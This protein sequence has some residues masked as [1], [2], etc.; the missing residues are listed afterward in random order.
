MEQNSSVDGSMDF[1]PPKKRKPSQNKHRF[2]SLTIH[3]FLVAGV[4]FKG[5]RSSKIPKLPYPTP[6]E[7]PV[8]RGLAEHITGIPNLNL[9]GHLLNYTEHHLERMAFPDY[10][11]PTP[12]E[13]PLNQPFV[14]I[15]G[16]TPRIKHY[17]YRNEYRD[18][19]SKLEQ[20]SNQEDPI[21]NYP[22][23]LNHHPDPSISRCIHQKQSK[24]YTSPWLG[25]PHHACN[26]HRQPLFLEENAF[27][28]LS[29][30]PQKPGH[31]FLLH[32]NTRRTEEAAKITSLFRRTNQRD[33]DHSPYTPAGMELA[34]KLSYH[35]LPGT[36]PFCM[37][38][39]PYEEHIGE[40][41]RMVDGY[42]YQC[43]MSGK[44]SVEETPNEKL[45]ILYHTPILPT[46][47]F[48][49]EEH[50]A[51]QQQIDPEIMAV[52]DGLDIANN[53]QTFPQAP[54]RPTDE[55]I[56]QE[57]TNC[58]PNH[59]QNNRKDLEKYTSP[60]LGSPHH[61]CNMHRQPLFLEENAST[62]LSSA[63]QKPRHPFIL[64]GNTRW[65]EEAAKLPP[66]SEGQIKETSTILLIPLL[67]W[68]W[69]SN[70]PTTPS[71]GPFLFVCSKDLM[72][73]TSVNHCAWLMDTPTSATC[74]G[75]TLSKK[76]QTKNFTS[77][78][79][80]QYCRLFNSIWKNI[81]H[82]NNKSIRRLWQFLMDLI[83][84]KMN[85]L[86]H[87]LQAVQLMHL[88]RWYDTWRKNDTIVYNNAL[89]F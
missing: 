32:G 56:Q 43:N 86:F 18:F 20:H 57:R 40:P 59:T 76:R 70:S 5:L 53:E 66:S 9:P 26:I 1:S 50:T 19:H 14:S 84:P 62:V 42:S 29:S 23:E 89:S 37:Q 52:F 27:T 67:E 77:S 87:K 21:I 88:G 35:A 11:R 4:E 48:H 46:F 49:M 60:W 63:P 44:D 30:A 24:K 51:Y 34:I 2:D 7:P 10:R 69:P 3:P 31:P 78:T 61:A 83:L 45:H 15:N 68:N 25:S 12:D 80:L 39:G 85:K 33:F 54:S 64:H 38:Q 17:P 13:H 79:T 71:Q 81:L 55:N 22:A 8:L 36:I 75:R 82:T 74:P 6:I 41:L 73:N 47:Q 65:T 72:K 16:T 28:V 58:I